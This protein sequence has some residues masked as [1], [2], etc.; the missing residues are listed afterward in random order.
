[1]LV[2]ICPVL[3][4]VLVVVTFML[5]A[6]LGQSNNNGTYRKLDYLL[7]ILVLLKCDPWGETCYITRFDSVIN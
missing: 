1:M 7:L 3:F 5:V 2:S 4:V 6:M